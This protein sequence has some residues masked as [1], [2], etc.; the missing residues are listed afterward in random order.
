MKKIRYGLSLALIW[1][2]ASCGSGEKLSS[3]G[4]Q[5]GGGKR[6]VP[7]MEWDKDS[8]ALVRAEW[9]ETKLGHGA[10]SRSAQVQLWGTVQSISIVSYPE[11]AFKTAVYQAAGMETTSNLAQKVG[12]DFA[13]NGSY[14]NMKTGAPCTFVMVDKQVMGQTTAAE[15]ELRVNG[16]I[17][18]NAPQH[19]SKW[20][21]DVMFAASGDSTS[22]QNH[23][24]SALAAG[25]VLI[26][27]GKIPAFPSGDFYTGRHPR[28]LIGKTRSG[29]V[30]MIVI[31]GRSAGN[32]VG[33][34]IGETAYVAR[35]LGLR[36]ALNL[37]GG[38]SS[39]LW[40]KKQGVVSHPSDNNAYD[41]SGER[42]VPNIVYAYFVGR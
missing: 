20:T 3:S 13:I 18:M 2:V 39:T 22:L 9:K 35:I 14:F 38:G 1:M 25:P 31:D 28:S 40:T 10:V 32:A 17:V 19:A 7:K 26:S 29:D 36:D 23:Y 24:T 4:F 37:D 21:T 41:H 33:T 42:K 15:E 11:R 16:A 12:A 30:M 8:I 34:T 27:D 5:D 6:I